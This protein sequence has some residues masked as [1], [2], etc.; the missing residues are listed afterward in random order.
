MSDENVGLNNSAEMQGA[1]PLP[2]STRPTTTTPIKFLI[3]SKLSIKPTA[4][5]EVRVLRETA[6]S[7]TVQ[8]TKVRPWET[9]PPTRRFYRRSVAG[10]FDTRVDA[11][12]WLWQSLQHSLEAQEQA[13]SET[14]R[15]A[16]NVLA[17]IKA[18]EKNS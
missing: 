16:E 5:R 8:A 2:G 18:E 3:E 9:A 10:L 7:F 11:L 14:N 6:T 12:R 15:I 1:D 4:I 17:E 13:I